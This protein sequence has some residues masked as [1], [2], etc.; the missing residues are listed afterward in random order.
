M[1]AI[2]NRLFPDADGDPVDRTVQPY[3]VVESLGETPFNTMGTQ[4][5]LKWGGEATIGIR[6]KSL[7]RSEA[8]IAQLV[9]YVRAALPDGSITVSGY[10]S[11]WLTYLVTDTP[12][13]FIAGRKVREWIVQYQVTA[14]QE[15]A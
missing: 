9:G 4:S 1:A 13:D 8:E 14:H 15:A 10:G 6:L 12:E 3:A 11:A 2:G 5:A 7:S